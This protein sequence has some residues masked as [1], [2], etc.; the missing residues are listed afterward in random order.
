M[1]RVIDIIWVEDRKEYLPSIQDELDE[2]QND[3]DVKFE[4]TPK[5]NSHEFINIA[6]NIPST[7]V[8]CIDYNLQNE[9]EGVD[10]DTVINNIRGVNRTCTIVFYSMKL[11]QAELRK[12][13]GTDPYTNCCSRNDLLQTLREM[14]EDGNI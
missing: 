11:N 4:I 10:G 5:Y 6:G 14:L 12:M 9:G 8:F 2:L 1:K 7:L 3:F 13:I